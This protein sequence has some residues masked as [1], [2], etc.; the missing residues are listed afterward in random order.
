MNRESV[1]KSGKWFDQ[2]DFGLLQ[3]EWRINENNKVRRFE[4]DLG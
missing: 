4:R 3:T 1:Y 2:I